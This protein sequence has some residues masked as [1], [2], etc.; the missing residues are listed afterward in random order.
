MTIPGKGPLNALLALGVVLLLTANTLLPLPVTAQDP[1]R[2]VSTALLIGGALL[3]LLALLALGWTIFSSAP[4]E[5]LHTGGIYRYSRHP[6]YL[7]MMLGFLGLA[8][9]ANNWI[10]LAAV[11]LLVIPPFLLK[12]L[13]EER[14][15]KE[16][17][18]EEWEAYRNRSAFLLPGIW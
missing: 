1:F 7:G 10:A 17:F 8:I 3:M 15:L 14:E 5:K 13:I 12:A 6:Y 2:Y 18:G 4:P 16:R 9:S 11:L